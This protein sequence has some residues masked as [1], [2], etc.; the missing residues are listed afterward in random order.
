MCTNVSLEL[1]RRKKIFGDQATRQIY[2]ARLLKRVDQGFEIINDYPEM[3]LCLSCGS[4]IPYFQNSLLNPPVMKM[5]TGCLKSGYID[6]TNSQDALKAIFLRVIEFFRVDLHIDILPSLVSMVEALRYSDETRSFSW[7]S[8]ENILTL[9]GSKRDKAVQESI[10]VHIV[11][12]SFFTEDITVHDELQQ[13]SRC[14]CRVVMTPSV[15]ED[16]RRWI[17]GIFVLEN[18]AFEAVGGLLARELMYGYM[19]LRNFGRSDPYFD[20][21][22]C[23]LVSQNFLLKE[24]SFLEKAIQCGDL[25]WQIRH[26]LQVCYHR[27]HSL[28]KLQKNVLYKNQLNKIQL[29]LK[30]YCGSLITFLQTCSSSSLY[31]P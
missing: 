25:R 13:L 31:T 22:V 1:Q 24:A 16:S 11:K 18:L 30:N 8:N 26:R 15:S 27:V 17:E 28:Y 10:P 21:A 6:L 2:D 19:W 4:V 29:E 20:V 9:Q 3:H 23:D 5:C 7:L 12:E 14:E